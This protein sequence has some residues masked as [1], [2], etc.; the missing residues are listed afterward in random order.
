IV[1]ERLNLAAMIGVR[2]VEQAAQAA[3]EH[4]RDT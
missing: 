3:E 1:S 2:D 4:L